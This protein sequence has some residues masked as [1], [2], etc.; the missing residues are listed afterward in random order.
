MIHA[1]DSVLLYCDQH[2]R[3]DQ[4]WVTHRGR[5]KLR[6]KGWVEKGLRFPSPQAVELS[7]SRADH[8]E[9]TSFAFC[10]VFSIMP[11]SKSDRVL[12]SQDELGKE[13]E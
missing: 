12:L 5:K 13:R 3:Y 10:R 6:S 11:L 1:V 4:Q 9:S 8:R 7:R 2:W